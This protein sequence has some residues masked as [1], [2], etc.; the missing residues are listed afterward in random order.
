MMFK[1]K[2]QQTLQTLIDNGTIT[3]ESPKTPWQVLDAIWTTMKSNNYF[4]DE[5]LSDVHQLPDE[6]IHAL[7][8]CITTLINQCKC[9]HPEIQ[10]MLKI[11]VPQ[12][13]VRFQEARD[14]I[15][16][17]D[18]SH[19][20]FM[21]ILSYS[22]LLKSQCKQYQ[23]AKEKGQADLTS[24]TT[25]TSSVL[26]IHQNTL[27]TF[28]KGSKCGYSHPQINA[29]LKAKSAIPEVAGIIILPR[30]DEAEDPSDPPVMPDL[31]S[32]H[33]DHP[34]EKQGQGTTHHTTGTDPANPKAPPLG[35]PAVP[36][37]I[38]F[39]QS[40]PLPVQQILQM[41]QKN[42]P[43]FQCHQDSI[44]VISAPSPPDSVETSRYPKE[45]YLLIEHTF[46]GQVSFYTCPMLPTKNGMKSM[47][48][49][50]EPGAQVNTIPLSRYQKIF[51]HKIN[52]SRYPKQRTPI[53][54]N[55]YWIS[56]NSKPKPLL[57]YFIADINHATQ[58]RSYLMWLYVFEDATSPQIP[59]SC[60]TSEHL[61]ILG[62]RAPNL[63]VQFHID[64]FT[65]P[66][67]PSPGGLWKTAKCV[68]FWDP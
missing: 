14:W 1:G 37:A 52:E 27:S 63:A 43:P 16:L 2:D 54:T 40:L 34:E 10:E 28:P 12:H 18:K 44:K 49:K 13:G 11:M 21:A 8:T 58:P 5:L 22:Q 17:Q 66:N 55:H 26:S 57:D 30:A 9:P 39:L 47:I 64:T 51:P 25:A 4:W 60:A 7:N 48:M 15:W 50:I 3:L 68:T 56:H 23:K 45:G 20:A 46:D 35:T 42:T 67:S 24:L 36:Q 19:L 31:S 33:A 61:G 65:T 62:F 6:S 38:P 59:L 32:V 29:W 41:Q 53:P